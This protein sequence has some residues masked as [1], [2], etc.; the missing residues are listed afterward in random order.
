MPFWEKKPSEFD[1]SQDKAI[2]ALIQNV[3]ALNKTDQT[4]WQW[5]QHLNNRIGNLEAVIQ[6]LQQNVNKLIETIAHMKETDAKITNVLD[7]L[8]NVAKETQQGGA[9]ENG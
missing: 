9:A 5:I 3:N 2:K 7:A 1:V 4:F 6:S 8:T